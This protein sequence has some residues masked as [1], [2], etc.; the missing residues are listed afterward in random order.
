MVCFV[1]VMKDCIF[2]N[3][4]CRVVTFDFFCTHIHIYKTGNRVIGVN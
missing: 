3:I 1:H 2:F 4:Q